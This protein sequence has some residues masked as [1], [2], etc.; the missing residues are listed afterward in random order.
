MK[1]NVRT[2]INFAMVKIEK[3]IELSF[4]TEPDGIRFLREKEKQYFW[5]FFTTRDRIVNI[6]ASTGNNEYSVFNSDWNSKIQNSTKIIQS[7]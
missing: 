2:M 3:K 6:S 1:L 5:N 7:F 4:T